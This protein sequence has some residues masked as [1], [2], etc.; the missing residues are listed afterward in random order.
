MWLNTGV[1]E[2]AK[3][4]NLDCCNCGTI[5]LS[6]QNILERSNELISTI[7]ILERDKLNF[8]ERKVNFENDND[9]GRWFKALNDRF[10]VIKERGACRRLV[11]YLS[12]SYL[13]R[14]Q[15]IVIQKLDLQ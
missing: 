14:R 1:S 3:L 11:H 13:A 5:K 12:Y 2:N 9:S 7:Y 6:S 8:I 10:A 15:S 4:F